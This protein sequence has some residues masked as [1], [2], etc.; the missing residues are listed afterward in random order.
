MVTIERPR[1]IVRQEI[2]VWSKQQRSKY[3]FPGPMTSIH[4]LRDRGGRSKNIQP[5]FVVAY[6][7]PATGFK[8][9]PLSSLTG[10]SM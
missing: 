8:S 4:R 1:E 3:R 10:R 6:D 5:G 2:I 7:A 9:W